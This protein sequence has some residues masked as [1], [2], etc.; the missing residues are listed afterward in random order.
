VW[1]RTIETWIGSGSAWFCVDENDR[2]LDRFWFGLIAAL[3]TVAP[4]SG[5]GA[6]GLLRRGAGGDEAVDRLLDDLDSQPRHPSVLVVDD[7]QCVDGHDAIAAE[8]ARFVRHL[9]AWLRLVLVSRRDVALPVDRMRSRGQLGEV[10]FDDLR[11]SPDEAA[12]WLALLAPDQAPDDIAA[13]VER[14][15]GWATSLRFSALAARHGRAQARAGAAV[16][17]SG[18]LV[19]D[20]LLREVLAGE[21]D[22]ILDVLSAAAIVPRINPGLGHAISGRSDAGDLLRMAEAH[23]LFVTRRGTSGW[24]ELHAPVRE[25]LHADLEARAPAALARLHERAARWLEGA[26]ELVDAL[27]QW[28]RAGRPGEALRLLATTHAQLYD[29]GHEDTVRRIIIAIPPDVVAG[30]VAAMVAFAWCHLLLNRRRFVDLV[31]QV[32]WWVERSAPVESV[33][34]RVTM[35]RSCAAMICGRW[36]EGGELARRAMDDLGTEW[37]QDPLG[38]FGWNIIARDVALTE[39]WDDASLDVRQAELALSR[40]PERR[41]AFEGTRALGHVL[42]GRPLDALRVA[43]GVRRGAAVAQMSVLRTE[44]RLAEALAHRELG[45]RARSRA[46]LTELADEPAETMLYCR[47]LAGLELARV[48]LDDG[49]HEAAVQA[50]DRA[51]A[52]MEAEGFDGRGWLTRVGVLLTLANGDL[53]TAQAWADSDRDPFSHG[54]SCARILLA[55]G[56]RPGAVAALD[57]AVPRGPRHEVVLGLLG[58]RAVVASDEAAKLAAD[59]VDVAARHGLLQTVASE[60]PDAI[61]LVEHAAWRAPAGWMNRLRRAAAETMSRPRLDQHE[62][63]EPLTDRE[64]AVLRLLP[65]R[66]T[67]RE[68]AD[69]LYV[70][71]NTVKFHLRVIYR[72]LGVNSRAEAAE[73]ARRTSLTRR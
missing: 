59:A 56:D 47:L 41:L 7:L 3:D 11:F 9:P 66:L 10:R 43:A 27:D 2:D 69:E 45:D 5:A 6:L 36:A 13:A 63:V 46:E 71:M 34:T 18:L 44:L 67:I 40:D 23:G 22:E 62:L 1:T 64:L 50:F 16:P 39:R 57:T 72:K 65:S 25:V 35:L 38:R 52:L 4:G 8:L 26:D 12:E 24:F 70:S 29:R 17:D 37:W 48:H 68:I 42:A 58:A 55:T 19:H 14:A 32:V 31:E 30:D 54:V 49:D 60:G 73:L 28:I 61:E 21:P 15:D 51:E 33:L 20:Y 53:D